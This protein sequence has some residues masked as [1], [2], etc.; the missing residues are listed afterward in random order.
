MNDIKPV[1]KNPLESAVNKL[2]ESAN[3][4]IQKKISEKVKAALD[5]QRIFNTLKGE[6][7]DLLKEQ[8]VQKN[9]VNVLLEELK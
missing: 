1:K 9:D 5:A 3:N 6:I 7:Q 2:K 4:E 8:E